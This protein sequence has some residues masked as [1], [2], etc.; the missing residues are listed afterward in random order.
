M[1]D[2]Q[3]VD[4]YFSYFQIIEL[5]QSTGYIVSNLKSE[6]YKTE[7]RLYGYTMTAIAVL[8]HLRKLTFKPSLWNYTLYKGS[9]DIFLNMSLIC[10][11]IY[12]SPLVKNNI[13]P[14]LS[15]FIYTV[16][17]GPAYFCTSDSFKVGP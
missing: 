5:L 17:V 12:W 6:K 4:R 16:L 11:V 8:V 9:T 2:Y 14:S 1:T 10:K 7:I 3:K 13:K 15:N